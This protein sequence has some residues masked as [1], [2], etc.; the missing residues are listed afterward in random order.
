MDTGL[1]EK[2][3]I[4]EEWKDPR[5]GGNVREINETAEGQTVE[6]GGNWKGTDTAKEGKGGG[7][8]REGKG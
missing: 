4:R 7:L 3:G 6:K 8:R 1:E 5:T 2:M